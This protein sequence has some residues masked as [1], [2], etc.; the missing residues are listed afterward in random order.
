[1]GFSAIDSNFVGMYVEHVVLYLFF[2]VFKSQWFLGISR[3]QTTHWFHTVESQWV[4][5]NTNVYYSRTSMLTLYSL[6]QLDFAYLQSLKANCMSPIKL[7]WMN[8]FVCQHPFIQQCSGEQADAD[9]GR[10]RLWW[11][12][13]GGRGGC[14]ACRGQRRG[15]RHIQ[16]LLLSLPL[17]P[18]LSLHHDD[19][20]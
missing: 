10:E 12:W 15:M 2:P 17:V 6:D 16:L 7:V 18:G 1:M 14:A 19:S 4:Q 3:W 13:G 5:N 20:H 8:V 9:R 11:G